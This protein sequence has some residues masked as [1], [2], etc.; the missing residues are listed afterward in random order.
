[1]DPVKTDWRWLAQCCAC[2]L[3]SKDFGNHNSRDS[4]NVPSNDRQAFLAESKRKFIDAYAA[5]G[6]VIPPGDFEAA[7]VRPKP[8]AYRK[9]LIEYVDKTIMQ[10]GESDDEDIEDLDEDLKG[11]ED[12]KNKEGIKEMEGNGAGR[13]FG[14]NFAKG[15]GNAVAD[16]YLCN[17]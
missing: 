3:S 9:A 2:L 6:I 17:F 8:R 13:D 14:S 16:R 5:V 12:L 7:F 11:D 10:R 4:G 15:A 1:M